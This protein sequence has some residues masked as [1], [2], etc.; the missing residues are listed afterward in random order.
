MLRGEAIAWIYALIL[1]ETVQM[2][3]D[4]L[5]AGSTKQLLLRGNGNPW[6]DS[7]SLSLMYVITS[8]P[9]LIDL[10]CCR[11]SIEAQQADIENA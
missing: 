10:D 9:P 3:H 6:M 8:L 1:L 2:V 11:L 5:V 4:A 7:S